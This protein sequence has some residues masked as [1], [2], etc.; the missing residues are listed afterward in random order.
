MHHFTTGLCAGL[1]ATV[2]VVGAQLTP[3]PAEAAR[4]SSAEVVAL[5][6]A[7]RCMQGRGERQEDLVASEPEVRQKL[8]HYGSQTASDHEHQRIAQRG[9]FKGFADAPTPGMGV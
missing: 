1:M 7:T 4:T 3:T 8:R 9:E 6:E 2:V 5:K